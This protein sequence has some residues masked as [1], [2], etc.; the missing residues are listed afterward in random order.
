MPQYLR[1][2]PAPSKGAAIQTKPACAGW[3]RIWAQVGGLGLCSHT[4]KGVG[5]SDNW[6]R[7]YSKNRVSEK[8]NTDLPLRIR[9]LWFSP[10][11][12]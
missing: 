2:N 12:S 7:Y 8:L 1:Q 11:Y 6:R 9:V 3:E 10:E 4:L 5:V